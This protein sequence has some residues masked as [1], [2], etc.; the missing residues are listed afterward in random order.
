[1]MT[2]EFIMET[3]LGKLNL[4]VKFTAG[5][6][7]VLAVLKSEYEIASYYLYCLNRYRI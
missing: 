5:K 7:K 6:P 1:M 4:I 3:P 2:Y